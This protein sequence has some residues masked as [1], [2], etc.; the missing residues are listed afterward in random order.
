MAAA[1]AAGWRPRW[2]GE[3]PACGAEVP[4]CSGLSEA[5]YG[6]PV[7]GSEAETGSLAAATTSRHRRHCSRRCQGTGKAASGLRRR[8]GRRS[9]ASA[10]D[11]VVDQRAPQLASRLPAVAAGAAHPALL[12]DAAVRRLDLPFPLAS[13]GR[14]DDSGHGG[15]NLTVLLAKVVTV[16]TATGSAA[17]AGCEMEMASCV[18]SGT[19]G[20]GA[21]LASSRAIGGSMPGPAT[22]TAGAEAREKAP[23]VEAELQVPPGA[24]TGVQPPPHSQRQQQQQQQPKD[25]GD[26][27]VGA[28]R[29]ELEREAARALAPPASAAKRLKDAVRQW[30]YARRVNGGSGFGA[31]A[32]GAAQGRQQGARQLQQLACAIGT[33]APAHAPIRA[34]ARSARGASG[35]VGTAPPGAAA[36]GVSRGS[37]WQWP[38]ASAREAQVRGRAV[39]TGVDIAGSVHD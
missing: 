16:A 36:A 32:G 30:R 31:A 2:P 37:R 6:A 38:A 17:G 18:L 24:R 20:R 34:L 1:R 33:E 23:D 26:G 39:G 5:I 22:G 3:Q 19:G 29:A 13:A 28:E 9:V 8:A 4:Q 25:V 10:T 11:D 21:A 14:D 12:A 15:G 35:G 27:G 7:S